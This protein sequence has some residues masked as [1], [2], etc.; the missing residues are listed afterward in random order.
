MK[1]AAALIGL[2]LLVACSGDITLPDPPEDLIERDSMVVV[3][4]DLVVIESL[5]QTRYQN[6]NT[7]YKVMSASG[8]KCLAKYHITPERF[9]RSYDY[10][11]TREKEL[12][13]IYAEVIDSLNREVSELSVKA[14]KANDTVAVAPH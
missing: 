1:L 10:Y 5:V 3:M 14:A 8:K 7:F 2:F 13:S 12:Q 4:R 6:I 11:V 9:E